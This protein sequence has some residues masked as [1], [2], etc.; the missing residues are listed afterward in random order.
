MQGEIHMMR[1]DEMLM[2]KMKTCAIPCSPTLTR[3]ISPAP[4]PWL[5]GYPLLPK[6]NSIYKIRQQI[7]LEEPALSPGKQDLRMSPLF[8]LRY[9]VPVICPLSSVCRPISWMT[10]LSSLPGYR[11]RGRYHASADVQD[12]V[13]D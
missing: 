8:D 3:W 7:V 2:K 10:K 13:R 1:A 4:Q 6:L 12:C 5:D 11:A 9:L